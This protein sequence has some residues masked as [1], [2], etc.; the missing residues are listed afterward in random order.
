PA[1]EWKGAPPEAR[2]AVGT[3]RVP[4]ERL[5]DLLARAGELLIARRRVEARTRDV[6]DLLTLVGQ[7]QA[8]WRRAERS[9]GKLLKEEGPAAGALPRRL[10]GTFRGAGENLRRPGKGLE[11]LTTAVPRGPRAPGPAA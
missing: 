3:A 1:G 10:A 5:D 11:R 9:F 7:W 4:A 6:A 8:E 2:G